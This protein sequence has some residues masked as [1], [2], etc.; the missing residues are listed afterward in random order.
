METLTT[1][2]SRPTRKAAD[3]ITASDR[4]RPGSG[5]SSVG[6]DSGAACGRADMTG[7]LWSAAQP[8]RRDSAILHL[9][10]IHCREGQRMPCSKLRSFLWVAGAFIN[11]ASSEAAAERARV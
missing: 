2:K 10:L 7:L 4:Q 11:V 6:A 5:D 1:K 8:S 3:R 9:A